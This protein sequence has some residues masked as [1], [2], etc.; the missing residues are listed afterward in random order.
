MHPLFPLRCCIY[1]KRLSNRPCRSKVKLSP[2]PQM[3]RLD[4]TVLSFS[5]LRLRSFHLVVSFLTDAFSI[6]PIPS[7][8]PIGTPRRLLFPAATPPPFFLCTGKVLPLFFFPP[9]L[10]GGG[11]LFSK[12]PAP[13]SAGTRERVALDSIFS[14]P[15]S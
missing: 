1:S 4:F 8:R 10:F 7:M 12:I 15:V 2:L 9:P 3:K 6:P 13:S 5:F 11:R 14:V